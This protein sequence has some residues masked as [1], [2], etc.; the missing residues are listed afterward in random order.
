MTLPV[1]GYQLKRISSKAYEHPAD[2][3]ATA[4]LHAVPHLDTVVRKVI[5][6]G[7]ERALRR[8]V[9]GSAVRLGGGQLTAV[10]QA[11]ERAYA[12]LDLAPVPDLYLT[13]FPI[14][15]A[16]TIG[17]GRP[18]VVVNSELV[19]LLD[20]EQLRGVF[21]HEAGHVL[22]DHVLY[23]TALVILL[24]LSRVPGV[25]VPL[26]PL[27]AALLEWFRAAELSCD[28]A[29]ALVIRDPVA[30]CRTLMIMAAG[31]E[32]ASLDLDLFMKQGEDYREKASPF[33]RFSRLLSDLN[34][35]HPMSVQRVHELMAWV[36]EGDYDRIVGGEYVTRDEPQRPREEAGAAVAHYAERFRDTFND[37]GDSINDAGQQLS[38]WLR[39]SRESS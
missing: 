26:T 28:R 1:E 17:A 36:K 10:W 29:A 5:E 22:S 2:R 18:I 3:A 39:R 11:H 37:L 25:P 23:R 14:A 15:N 21:G 35:T 34:L 7:Y 12:T 4:A 30:V 13:Q 19:R 20:A 32:A 33:D 16:I 27:K 8:G 6:F 31:A 38:D 24:A 9:L